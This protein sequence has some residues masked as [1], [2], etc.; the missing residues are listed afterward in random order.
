M[1]FSGPVISSHFK[2]LCIIIR[3]AV[4]LDAAVP[5]VQRFPR[6]ILCY[7]RCFVSPLGRSVLRCFVTYVRGLAFRQILLL[8]WP[9]LHDLNQEIE[10][11]FRAMADAIGLLLDS[12]VQKRDSC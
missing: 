9:G 4:E 1:R 10:A 7:H 11:I 6:L 3:D 2:R 8:V 5:P 12:R